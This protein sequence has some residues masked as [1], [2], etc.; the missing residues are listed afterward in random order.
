MFRGTTARAV[1]AL[2]AAALL[3]LQLFAPTGPF[4]T[5]HTLSHPQAKAEPETPFPAKPVRDGAAMLH[6]AGGS[7][8]P[9]GLPRLRDPQRRTAS[10]CSQADPLITGRA[11]GTGPSHTPRT[12]HD[13]APRVS[14]AHTPAA[15]QVFRC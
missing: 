6:A 9:V 5:T 1:L 3:A 8:A 13:P 11:A 12:A 15:L 7:G 14:R 4:A 10:G 2:L